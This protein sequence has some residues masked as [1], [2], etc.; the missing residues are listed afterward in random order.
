M[1][2]PLGIKFCIFCRR[3]I[4]FRLFA[5]CSNSSN[6]SLRNTWSLRVPKSSNDNWPVDRNFYNV[7]VVSIINYSLLEG[8][9][10]RSTTTQAR[11]QHTQKAVR[12]IHKRSSL[13]G[14][15]CQ[16]TLLRI[17]GRRLGCVS[18]E[19]VCI[20]ELSFSSPQG[21]R[22]TRNRIWSLEIV[23]LYYTCRCVTSTLAYIH[24][25]YL[26]ILEHKLYFQFCRAQY[27]KQDAC[28]ELT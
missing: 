16:C 26:Y 12:K 4:I 17:D 25:H 19:K 18:W 13:Y 21:K 28:Q 3:A 2:C 6:V 20:F 11:R 10:Q 22:K 8:K 1:Y 24:W 15:S 27:Q 7:T 5:I 14:F 23:F 9:Q